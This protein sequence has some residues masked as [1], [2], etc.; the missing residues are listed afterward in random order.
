M[1]G[2]K[3]MKEVKELALD[4]VTAGVALFVAQ[5]VVVPAVTALG[6]TLPPVVAYGVVGTVTVR[7]SQLIRG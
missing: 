4:L 1:K 2:D 7:L 6:F 5:T 3:P